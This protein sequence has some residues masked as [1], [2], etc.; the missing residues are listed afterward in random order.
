MKFYPRG[1]NFTKALLVTNITSDSNLPLPCQSE[2]FT[3]LLYRLPNPPFP[4]HIPA[5]SVFTDSMIP[6]LGF[7]RRARI[8][9]AT[10]SNLSA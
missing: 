10:L 5:A 3:I 7:I 1:Y 2:H 6:Q 9:A 4:P 8:L